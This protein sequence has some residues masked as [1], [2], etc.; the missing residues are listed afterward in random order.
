MALTSLKQ[1]VSKTPSLWERL[2]EELECVAGAQQ[3]CYCLVNSCILTLLESCLVNHLVELLT[4]VSIVNYDYDQPNTFKE[5][6]ME[7]GRANQR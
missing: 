4:T 5:Q 1:R 7:V 3:L 2:A 6:T